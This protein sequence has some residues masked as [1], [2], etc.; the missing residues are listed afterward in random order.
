MLHFIKWG[1]RDTD[2]W[3]CLKVGLNSKDKAALAGVGE[4]GVKHPRSVNSLGENK[5][6]A[7]NSRMN[8]KMQ[9]MFQK[10]LSQEH[11]H[12]LEFPQFTTTL[13]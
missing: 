6:I 2:R 7:N 13:G 9:D 5:S 8:E 1:D 10:G 4:G 11:S 12:C 3:G